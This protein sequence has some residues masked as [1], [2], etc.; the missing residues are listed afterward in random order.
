MKIKRIDHLVITTAL[1]EKCIA[2][3]SALGFEPKIAAGKIELFSNDFKI[4]VH[5]KGKELNPHARHAAP[6]SADLCFEI[7]GNLDDVAAE[8]RN[9]GIEIKLEK[10]TR[11]GAFGNMASIYLRDPDGNLIELSQ[12]PEN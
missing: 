10:S 6:G 4:N 1:P 8:I 9:K 5:I 3:Y 2:F 7:C 11:T 12:Y